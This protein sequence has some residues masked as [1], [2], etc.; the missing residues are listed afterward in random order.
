M[1]AGEVS[2][3]IPAGQPLCQQVDASAENDDLRCC[4]KPMIFA[5]AI[6]ISTCCPIN[7]ALVVI[8]A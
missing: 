6:G 4:I 8:K 2:Q 3:R 7:R 1:E 5:M